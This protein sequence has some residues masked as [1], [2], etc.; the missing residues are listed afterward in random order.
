MICAISFL[1][2]RALILLNTFLGY[3]LGLV[4]V[5]ISSMFMNV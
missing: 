3:L 2:F 4:I 1:R 5:N